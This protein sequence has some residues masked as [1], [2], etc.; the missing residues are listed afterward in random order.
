MS[1]F[2]IELLKQELSKY[3]NVLAC[4]SFNEDNNLEIKCKN[5]TGRLVTYQRIEND[6]ILPYY[7]NVIKTDFREGY[8]KAA[9]SK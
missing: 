1:S 9:F 8:Y 7:P 6:L 2:N 3:G 4:S 5:S